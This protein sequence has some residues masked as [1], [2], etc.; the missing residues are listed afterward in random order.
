MPGRYISDTAKH[1]ITISKRI[2]VLSLLPIKFFPLPWGSLTGHVLHYGDPSI[3]DVH[4]LPKAATVAAEKPYVYHLLPASQHIGGKVLTAAAGPDSAAEYRIDL[5]GEPA[6]VYSYLHLHPDT[7]QAIQG[8]SI[9]ISHS[10]GVMVE[11][12]IRQ[13]AGAGLSRYSTPQDWQTI[14]SGQPYSIDFSTDHA[15]IAAGGA[16]LLEY[17]TSPVGAGAF[18]P[19]S[20][21]TYGATLHIL[22]EY[23]PRDVL[24]TICDEKDNYRFGFNGQEKDNEAKGIGNSINYEA[25]I[26]DTRLG[27]FLSVDPLTSKFPMLTPYQ[28]ASNNPIW[29]VDMDGLEGTKY[30]QW[31]KLTFEEKKVI[32]TNFHI[33]NQLQK[34]RD[35]AFQKTA[36]LFTGTES[37]KTNFYND[38]ADAFRHA[39]FNAL[40]TQSFGFV[41]ANKLGKA[42]EAL[43]DED[44][45]KQNQM[46]MDLHNNFVGQQIGI[47]NPNATP[48]EM[49]EKVEEK[50]I[51]GSMVVLDD[52]TDES[53]SSP[54]VPSNKQKSPVRLRYDDKKDKPAKYGGN[55]GGGSG[56]NKG[57]GSGGN[58]GGGSG[59][60]KKP[61]GSESKPRT[62]KTCIR[63][64]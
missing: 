14:P 4:E 8:L 45:I 2:N 63:L 36:E 9:S 58:K 31:Q 6:P 21:V 61:S 32:S 25:R 1:C 38:E 64:S 5:A 34:N 54:L 12:R 23:T 29:M 13:Y 60:N 10:P 57:G 24:V 49:A 7:A 11:A 56:G 59:G 35:L 48:D 52:P 40:N 55:K 20:A 3:P 28:F 41:L 43:D 33:I 27:R 39:Y 42:H 47:E 46:N 62:P 19:L 53:G 16:T 17:R 30:D 26:Q 51:A 44:K 22:S 37:E 50:R 15:A 18:V